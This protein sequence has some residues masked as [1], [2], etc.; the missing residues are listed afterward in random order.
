MDVLDSTSWQ[1][2]VVTTNGEGCNCKLQ[3]SSSS[4]HR[5]KNLR[6]C[7]PSTLSPIDRF[8]ITR[9][10]GVNHSTNNE[11]DRHKQEKT[12]GAAIPTKRT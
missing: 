1:S 9:K 11:I 4:I 6:K 8:S 5:G 12:T 7:F 2:Q 10:A 3:W